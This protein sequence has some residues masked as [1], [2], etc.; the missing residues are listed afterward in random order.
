[1][2]ALLVVG[3][4]GLL[5]QHVVAEASGRYRVVATYRDHPPADTSGEA[6]RVDLADHRGAIAFV[7]RLAPWGVV[8]AGALTSVDYCET[9]PEEARAVNG[10]APALIAAACA[11]TGTRLVHLSTDYVFDG[12]AGPYSEEDPPNPLGV[13]GRVKLEGEQSVL[14]AHRGACVVRSCT[15]FGW[16]R[17]TGS[18]NF[19]TWVLGELEGGRGVGLWGDQ[20]VSPTYASH[21]S[22][23]LLRLLEAGS[24]GLFHVASPTCLSRW[25]FGQ[26]IADAFELPRGKMRPTFMASTPLEAPRPRHSCL[27]VGK[28]EKELNTQMPTLAEALR[29]MRSTR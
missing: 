3:A 21:A 23:I 5:G 11:E 17:L 24:R 19:V 8:M 28:V 4:S 29:D 13:Y 25:E 22:R 9:H 7:R 2:E 26:L 14:E 6:H 10:V 20:F 18:K 15:L 27:L 12:E 1:V 16:N